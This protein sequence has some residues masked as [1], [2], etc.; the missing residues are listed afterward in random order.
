MNRS[1]HLTALLLAAVMV[2]SLAACGS[3]EAASSHSRPEFHGTVQKPVERPVPTN[4]HRIPPENTEAPTT[5]AAP[6]VTPLNTPAEPDRESLEQI[7]DLL[8]TTENWDDLTDEELTDL[9]EDQL[10]REESA[11]SPA[12]PDEIPAPTDP[13]VDTDPEGYDEN[14]AMT[15]PF[16]QLYPELV[17]TEQVGYDDRTLL[18]KLPLSLGGEVTEQMA[19]AGVARLELLFELEN[20]AWYEARLVLGTDVPAAV[21]TLRDSGEI[22]MVDYNYAVR[23][24]DIGDYA[25][26]PGHLLGNTRVG[27]QWYLNTCG[28]YDGMD[29]LSVPGGS[30]SVIVA[31][32]DTGV[33]YDHE[34]LAGN[35]WVNENEI[36]DDGID[37]DGNGY[38]DDYYGVN[39]VSGTG[40]GD[41]DNG[42]GTHVAGI[43]AARNNNLGTV[44]IAYNVKVMPIKAA[45]ARASCTSPTSPVPSST[46]TSTVLRSSTCPSA[47]PPAPLPSRMPWPWPMPTAFWWH[48]PVMMAHPTR[49]SAPSP[50]TPPP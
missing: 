28:I 39:I 22:L 43:I 14:G 31:V 44:G 50:T 18:L 25:Q 35:I 6:V 38:V 26:V 19:A 8:D 41:D 2:L 16:D 3:R 21:Q 32:I 23:T 15:V 37:N 7:A 11:D 42:H 27:E 36:P 34:D 10:R 40:N 49:A 29:E 13:A 12:D 5:P 1:L 48:P 46:P 47:A 30:S 17:E 24:A 33:D 20:A 4:P 45:M 9:I